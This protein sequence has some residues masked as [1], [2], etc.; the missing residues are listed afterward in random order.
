MND[1][2]RFLRLTKMVKPHIGLLTS[3]V[4]FGVAGNL[5]SIGL[6][7]FAAAAAAKIIGGGGLPLGLIVAAAVC[8]I[9]RGGL[10]YGEHY[11]GHD[12]AFRLL[13]DIRKKIFAAL[14]R[15]APA[16]L[17]D[18]KTGD[19]CSAVM[20]DVEFIETFFAHTLA[21]III[22]TIVPLTVM[23]VLAA[24]SIW[25]AL[26]ILP[27]Y[28]LMGILVPVISFRSAA[29]YG[30]IYRGILSGMN[31]RLMEN[32][33]GLRELMLFNRDGEHLD[34]LLDDTLECGK[35]YRKIRRNEGQLASLTE[36]IILSAAASFAA[37]GSVLVSNGVIEIGGFVTAVVLSITSF[38]PLISLMFL[39]N[40]LVNTS[41]A[42][43]HIF[44]LLDEEPVVINPAETDQDFI[45]GFK[46]SI[47]PKAEGVDFSY[48]GSDKTVLTG[49]S[50]DFEKDKIT[51]LKAGS[52]AGKSTILYLMMRFF[53]PVTGKMIMD[54]NELPK[55]D[56]D[57]IR[58]G[59]SYFTQDTTLFNI[60]IMENIRMANESAS[61][62]DVHEAA[63][64]AGIHD[65][66]ISL[67]D[68]YKTL[69]GERGSRFSS[70][71]RQRIGLARIFLQNNDVIFLDEP[72][73]N[74]DSENEKLIMGNLKAGLKGKTVVLVSHRP[75]V[76]SLADEVVNVGEFKA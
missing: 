71:E 42:A 33:Q 62:Q 68:G 17:L 45:Q 38:G 21:P 22:G 75:S 4:L 11:L 61:D 36:I 31:S 24:I 56:L 25:F 26:L 73:S 48:P 44:E 29:D 34:G 76:V 43:E 52:G 74:L 2:K 41:A 55:Y 19:I 70:G 7:G 1:L 15:L 65:F 67:P 9:I 64:K 18:R 59:V 28:L 27:F 60:S 16:K 54:G 63:Q 3:S 72:V 5:S 8:G 47:P 32:L 40:N 30:R 23:I 13:F 14:N 10:R 20:A 39:S 6:L 66:I 50:L 37:L 12:I 58:S 53:D 51:A 57:G 46:I 49:L 69:A 35:S